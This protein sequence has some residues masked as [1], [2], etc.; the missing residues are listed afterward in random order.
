MKAVVENATIIANDEMRVLNEGHVVLENG[1]ISKLSLI[2]IS[3]PTRP[4]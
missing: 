2:H 4:Y 1:R 3:E